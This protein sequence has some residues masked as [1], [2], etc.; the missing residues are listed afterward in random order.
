MKILI[1]LFL[2]VPSLSHAK[3]ILSGGPDIAAGFD[4]SDVKSS[5]LLGIRGEAEYGH[6]SF[7]KVTVFGTVTYHQG[8]GRTQYDYTDPSDNSVTQVDDVKTKVSLT[9]LNAG[10][11]YKVIEEKTLSFFA[12]GGFQFGVLNLNLDRNNF[13]GKALVTDDFE[14]NENQNFWGVFGEIGGEMKL[15]ADSALR[16]SGQI[17]NVSTESF[18]ILGE[19]EVEFMLVTVAMSYVWYL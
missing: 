2:L 3:F 12:G 7:P 1:L 17:S 5:P 8:P 18:E 4:D 11:R 16:L 19:R 6:A 14:Q 13:K 9:R 10:F 15:N